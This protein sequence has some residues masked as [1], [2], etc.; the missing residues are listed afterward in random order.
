MTQAQADLISKAQETLRA[1]AWLISGDFNAHA[2][3]RIYYAMFYS[4]QAVLLE[5]GLTFSKHSSTISAF[6]QHFIKTGL[7][8]AHLHQSL[9]KAFDNRQVGDYNVTASISADE[10]VALL[11]QAEEFVAAITSF[12]EQSSPPTSSLVNDPTNP[13]VASDE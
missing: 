12:I 5:R 8:D 4:A 2:V 10:A 7:L 13:T 3:S 11:N 9:R 6:G 1:S